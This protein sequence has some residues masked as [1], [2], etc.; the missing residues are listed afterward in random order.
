MGTPID[1]EPEKSEDIG[2]LTTHVHLA[3]GGLISY[4]PS[5]EG[6]VGW[7]KH[8]M[9]PYWSINSGPISIASW[10]REKRYQVLP[11]YTYLR[12]GVAWERGYSQNVAYSSRTDEAKPSVVYDQ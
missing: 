5:V 3:N 2:Q 11:T 12:A 7:T 8:K 4:T 6:I 9:L 10:S 1:L